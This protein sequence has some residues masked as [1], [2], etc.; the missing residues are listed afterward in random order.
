MNHRSK[1]TFGLVAVLT[2][3]ALAGVMLSPAGAHVTG[4]FRHL[5]RVHI[6]P[7]LATPGSF[8]DP[9]NPVDWSKL[10]G[11]PLADA[12]SINDPGNPVDWTQLKNVPAGLADGTDDTAAGGGGG[13]GGVAPGIAGYQIVTKSSPENSANAKSAIAECPAGKV[14]VGGG[15]RT[16]GPAT[17]QDVLAVETSYP[18]SDGSAWH[19][20]AHEQPATGEVWRVE[21]HAICATRAP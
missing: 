7:K 12:G 20:I 4:R 21:A 18:F 10:K 15:A 9:R 2:A 3:V 13:G 5:W 14:A 17:V 19:V 1:K 11:V 16:A 6:K 8:N